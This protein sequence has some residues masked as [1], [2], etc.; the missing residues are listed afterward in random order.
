MDAYENKS[1]GTTKAQRRGG[2]HQFKI[3]NEKFKIGESTRERDEPERKHG[4]LGLLINSDSYQLT[5]IN[6]EKWIVC[7]RRLTLRARVSLSV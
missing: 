4:R 1:H 5:V 3:Q 6:S 2:A 7:P